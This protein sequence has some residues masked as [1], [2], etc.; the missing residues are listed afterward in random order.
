MQ[1]HTH[2]PS[3]STSFLSWVPVFLFFIDALACAHLLDI[4]YSLSFSRGLSLSD[5]PGLSLLLFLSF[6]VYLDVCLHAHLSEAR[7]ETKQQ[8]GNAYFLIYK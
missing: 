1:V 3:P 6:S 4:G 5:S 2:T 8:M 7:K